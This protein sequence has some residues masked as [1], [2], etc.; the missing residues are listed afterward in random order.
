M[1]I[2]DGVLTNSG[3][4]KIDG[5]ARGRFGPLREFVFGSGLLIDAA[6]LLYLCVCNLHNGFDVRRLQ[7]AGLKRVDVSL[8]LRRPYHIMGY[9]DRNSVT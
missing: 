2:L 9:K 8:Q 3:Y 7:K 5:S 1:A 4:N 6:A